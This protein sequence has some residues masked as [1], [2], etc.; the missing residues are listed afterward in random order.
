[1]AKGQKIVRFR[2][3][4]SNSKQGKKAWV[5]RVAIR[6]EPK[7]MLIS[8]PQKYNTNMYLDIAASTI[9]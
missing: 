6:F 3:K 9:I 5:M 1:L 2:P 8:L 4:K 7:A